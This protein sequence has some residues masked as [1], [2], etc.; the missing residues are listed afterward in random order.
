MKSPK[1]SALGKNSTVSKRNRSKQF[2]VLSKSDF[3]FL[4]DKG[5]FR[6]EYSTKRTIS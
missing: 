3:H 5:L 6:N 2:R 4:R 1:L